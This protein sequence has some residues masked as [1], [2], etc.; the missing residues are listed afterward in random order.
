MRFV[1]FVVALLIAAPAF[2]LLPPQVYEQARR[3]AT[4]VIIIEVSDVDEP[5][6]SGYGQCAVRGRVIGVLRG[7][8]YQRGYSAIVQVP[9][10]HDSA[11]TPIGGMI[12]QSFEQLRTYPY[13]RAYLDASG[14]LAL[15]QYEPLSEWTEALPMP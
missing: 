1:V 15:S 5:P 2:A 11:R 4:D 10:R 6:I 8:R 13:G 9:C 14:Q 12:Y 3:D 7:Q